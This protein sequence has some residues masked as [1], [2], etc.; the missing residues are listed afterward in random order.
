MAMD[1]ENMQR[2]VNSAIT[3]TFKVTN[4]SQMNAQPTLASE[5]RCKAQLVETLT[6]GG[7]K[8][9]CTNYK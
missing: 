7:V 9:M 6:R 3:V 2:L 1:T 8:V 5:L 4:I